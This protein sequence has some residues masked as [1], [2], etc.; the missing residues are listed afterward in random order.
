MQLF[1][2]SGRL[3]GYHTGFAYVWAADA[4]AA[5]S[6]LKSRLVED[7]Y[8][9]TGDAEAYVNALDAPRSELLDTPSVVYIDHGGCC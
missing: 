9:S 3:G 5:R 1:Y 2:F 8:I 6:L 4:D 7:G